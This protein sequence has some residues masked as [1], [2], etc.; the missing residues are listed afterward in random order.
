MLFQPEPLQKQIFL[1]FFCVC[2]FGICFVS[3]SRSGVNHL[4]ALLTLL[5]H[6]HYIKTGRF[7]GNISLNT[8]IINS[9]CVLPVATSATQS[10]LLLCLLVQT[11]AVSEWIRNQPYTLNWRVCLWKE[12]HLQDGRSTKVKDL[13]AMAEWVKDGSVFGKVSQTRLY[14]PTSKNKPLQTSFDHFAND[15]RICCFWTWTDLNI[16]LLLPFQPFL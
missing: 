4:Q 5:N 3:W 16:H 1:F 2:V 11:F 14:Q 9:S 7:E 8:R 12:L 13:I 6:K 15:V 10:V